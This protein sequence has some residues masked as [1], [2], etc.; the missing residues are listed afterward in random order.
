MQIS[1]IYIYSKC[2]EHINYNHIQLKD[3]NMKNVI[4]GLYITKIID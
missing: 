4:Q 2:S 3:N 1:C